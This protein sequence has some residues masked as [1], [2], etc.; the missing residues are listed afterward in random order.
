LQRFLAIED[1]PSAGFST[2]PWR[3]II[4]VE[5]GVVAGCVNCL[6]L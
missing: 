5:C 1:A 3:K 2:E 6:V 4:D